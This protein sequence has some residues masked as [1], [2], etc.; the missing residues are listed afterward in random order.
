MIT[1]TWAFPQFEVAPSEDGMTD[2]V[3]VIHWTLNAQDGAFN[4]NAYGT[5][6]LEAPN[7]ASFKPYADITEQWA[8]DVTSPLI[9]LATIQ[10]SMDGEI[11]K[12]KSP[13]VVP[14]DPPF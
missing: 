7:P 10:A 9:D 11:K 12:K 14:M 3:K 2:V 6:A 5:V 1:Y 13:S 4:S 8:I